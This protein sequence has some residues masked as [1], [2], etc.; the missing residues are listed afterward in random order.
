MSLVPKNIPP[1]PS[2]FNQLRAYVE[3]WLKEQDPNLVSGE[4]PGHTHSSDITVGTE[5][6]Q[7]LYWNGAAWVASDTDYLGWSATDKEQTTEIAKIKRLL[8]GG[9]QG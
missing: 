5:T 8:A 3:R 2:D 9:V 1:V 7:L 4:D 6:G